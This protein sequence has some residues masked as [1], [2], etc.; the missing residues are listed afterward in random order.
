[1]CKGRFTEL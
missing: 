1:M